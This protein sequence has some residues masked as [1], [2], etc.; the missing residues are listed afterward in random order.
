MKL[1]WFHY[2]QNNS[3]GFFDG[4]ENVLVQA[5]SAEEADS[6]AERHGIYFG[7]VSSGRDCECCGNRW[8]MAYGDGGEELSVYGNHPSGNDLIVPYVTE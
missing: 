7:G 1:T 5:H 3:G 8:S 6:I 4:P 2:S